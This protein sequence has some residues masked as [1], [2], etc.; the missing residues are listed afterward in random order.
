M[1]ST[2]LQSLHVSNW[3]L[4]ELNSR[5]IETISGMFGERDDLVPP[6]RLIDGIGGGD[7]QKIGR[8]FFAY[9]TRIGQLQPHHRVLD[10]GCGCGRMA[11]PMI[12]FLSGNADYH[13]FD[14]VP[15]A[16]KWSRNH[17]TKRH[18]RFHFELADVIAN[19][20]TPAANLRPV[21]MYSRTRTIISILRC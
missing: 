6:R 10:V 12:P 15:D 2:C 7:F 19:N 9:F 4:R 1:G 18:A 8:E 3:T 14:I 20:T 5:L 11:V 17:I 13:G 16:I 21:S